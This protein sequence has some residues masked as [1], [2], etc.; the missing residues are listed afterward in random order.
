MSLIA[1]RD[2]E[3][4]TYDPELDLE[5]KIIFDE[6]NK[7]I[8]VNKQNSTIHDIYDSAKYAWRRPRY[9]KY[10]FPCKLVTDNLLT[11][12]KPWRID[13]DTIT[14]IDSGTIQY[15]DEDGE[16]LIM[17]SAGYNFNIPYLEGTLTLDTTL[18]ISGNGVET[19]NV[20]NTITITTTPAGGTEWAF[21]DRSGYLAEDAFVT[22]ENLDNILDGAQIAVDRGDGQGVQ[23]FIREFGDEYAPANND[24]PGE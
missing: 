11:L 3:F 6:V 17:N 21:Q 10:R 13:D 18:N 1:Y 19:D 9:N 2:H 8:I 24:S 14:N 16:K 4:I 15:E 20:D 22:A 23:M 5:D 12:D 7:L